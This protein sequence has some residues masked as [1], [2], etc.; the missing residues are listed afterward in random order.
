M[1]GQGLVERVSPAV[2]R[3]GPRELR[4]GGDAVVGVRM[5]FETDKSGIGLRHRTSLPRDDSIR[6]WRNLVR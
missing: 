1:K 6:P 2:V 4:R 3:T 5:V